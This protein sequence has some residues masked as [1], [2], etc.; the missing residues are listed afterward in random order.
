MFFIRFWL[1]VGIM[2]KLQFSKNTSQ[3][4][5]NYLGESMLNHNY[6]FIIP[7]KLL[8]LLLQIVEKIRQLPVLQLYLNVGQ[9]RCKF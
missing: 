2:L 1:N 9:V 8:T 4:N 6:Y 3:S 7:D 5:Y